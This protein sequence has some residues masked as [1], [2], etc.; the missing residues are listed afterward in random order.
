[1]L[2]FHVDESLCTRCK[3]CVRDC[4]S[5]VI[6]L[7]KEGLS[8]VTPE[9]EP[10]CIRCQHCL[11]IC[12]SAAIS[13]L[14]K[15]PEDSLALDSAAKPTLDAMEQLVRGRRT[16]RRYKPENVAPEVIQRL[17]DSTAYAPTG[18]NRRALTFSV[19]DNRD[20]MKA[21]RKRAMEALK[22]A[23]AADAV[24]EQ[25]SYLHAAV[26]AFFAHGA[27]LIFRGAPHLLLVSAGP[28]SLCPSEDVVIAL[29]TFE[30]LA[31]AAGLGTTWCGMLKMT[32]ES[33]PELKA[34]FGLPEDA[35][36]YAMLFGVPKAAYART[37][38]REGT[39]T[40]QRLTDET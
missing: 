35:P 6:T 30:M 20:A 37:T 1:M 5:R 23:V 38:Q 33:V 21:I 9:V 18:A 36:Y 8:T 22:A 2:D 12:P 24:P 34:L 4:P 19:V 39:A 25:F 10:N 17:L 32:L 26:P 28:D 16:T 31:S 3:E 40:I 27:D 29:S 14:G 15:R 11:A 13:I 7:S